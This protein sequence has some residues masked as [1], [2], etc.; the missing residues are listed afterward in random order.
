[1]S[2]RRLVSKLGSG[3]APGSVINFNQHHSSVV[4]DTRVIH[5]F[6][7]TT[8]LP[9]LVI[10]VRSALQL[11]CNS[12]ANYSTPHGYPLQPSHLTYPVLLVRLI[13][14]FAFSSPQPCSRHT[15]QSA[16]STL[17]ATF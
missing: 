13:S 10:L 1:M 8:L 3:T 14:V 15:F 16:C 7:T 2:L 4:R 11:T 6:N 17:P 12:E 9:Q 5:L